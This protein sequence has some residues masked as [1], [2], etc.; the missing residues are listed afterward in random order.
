MSR[1]MS[2]WRVRVFNVKDPRGGGQDWTVQATTE[3]DARLL[4][5]ALAGGWL[6]GDM[7]AEA[8]ERAYAWTGVPELVSKSVKIEKSADEMREAAEALLIVANLLAQKHGDESK[9][10]RA[11][12]AAEAL[13]WAA[14]EDSKLSD[15]IK[16]AVELSRL[17]GKIAVS[18]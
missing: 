15:R 12:I 7:D 11:A 13:L 6:S 1:G 2:I 17:Q 18:N 14:G 16:D 10:E 4:A 8:I 5:F 3:N 9:A